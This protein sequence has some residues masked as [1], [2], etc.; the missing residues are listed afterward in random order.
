MNFDRWA[1]KDVEQMFARLDQMRV[2]APGPTLFDQ[3]EFCE[4]ID[5]V[6][7]RI[8]LSQNPRELLLEAWLVIDYIV[9]YLLR[10]ALHIPECID[11]ELRLIPFQFEKKI[12]LIKRLRDIE[13]KKLPNQKSYSAFE[14]HPDFHTEVMKDKEFHRKLLQ[15]ACRFEEDRCPKEA[16]ALMRSDFERSRFVP[17]WWYRQMS[18]LDDEWFQTCKHLNKARNLAAHKLKMTSDEAFKEFGVTCLADFK[19]I[20]KETIERIVF[21]ERT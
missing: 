1:D 3:L 10:D 19:S 2:H 11:S 12:D 16:L 8:E 5:A 9:T 21:R 15:L 14:L 17:E 7:E 20:L 18:A 6:F 13:A 4:H